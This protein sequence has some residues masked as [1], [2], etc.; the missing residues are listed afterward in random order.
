NDLPHE[1][2]WYVL[3]EG[4]EHRFCAGECHSEIL[5]LRDHG[6]HRRHGPDIQILQTFD[7]SRQPPKRSRHGT[8]REI[9]QRE[10]G[11]HHKDGHQERLARTAGQRTQYVIHRDREREV[12]AFA[13]GSRDG[14]Q[15]SQPFGTVR[16]R[17]THILWTTEPDAPCD[18]RHHAA[19]D[20]SDIW[21]TRRVCS[22]EH[23]LIS[24]VVRMRE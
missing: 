21:D 11:Q 2:L 18:E 24:Y 13:E 17:D 19:T 6:A 9:N 14:C 3:A 22:I 5:Y 1:I 10:E 20:L 4:A 15:M 16:R 8:R 7:L 12:D 23:A